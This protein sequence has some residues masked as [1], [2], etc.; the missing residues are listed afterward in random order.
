M[1]RKRI[2]TTG[3]SPLELL[4]GRSVR[5]PLDVLKE[6]WEGSKKSSENVVSHILQIKEM[7][8]KMSELAQDNLRESNSYQKKWYD[9]H[10]REKRSRMGMKF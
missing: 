3:F 1:S 6:A 9:Q 8:D 4:Y 10:A 2:R 7:T 5:G